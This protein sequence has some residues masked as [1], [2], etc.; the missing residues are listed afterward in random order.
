M[1]VLEE[2]RV[3]ANKLAV[4]LQGVLPNHDWVIIINGY[5]IITSNSISNGEI[6]SY[7]ELCQLARNNKN[8]DTQEKLIKI[9]ENVSKFINCTNLQNL[10]KKITV[11][12]IYKKHMRFVSYK[13]EDITNNFGRFSEK[14]KLMINEYDHIK[15]NKN[16]E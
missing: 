5:F 7:N 10:D 1:L 8:S 15:G 4:E 16:E 13:P 14:I 3:N 12:F 2:I 11:R 9:K 6:L